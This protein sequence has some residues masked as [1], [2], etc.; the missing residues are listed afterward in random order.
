[1]NY[2][3]KYMH[4]LNK[5]FNVVTLLNFYLI[6]RKFYFNLCFCLFRLFRLILPDDGYFV[7]RNVAEKLINV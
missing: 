3:K 5:I 4:R 7:I 6:F 2:S 1:M